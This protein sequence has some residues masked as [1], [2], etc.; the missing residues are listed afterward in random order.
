MYNVLIFD[1]YNVF[2]RVFWHN[3]STVKI[4]NKP[5][6]IDA[7]C[8]F[9]ELCNGYIEKFGMK[10]DCKIYWLFDNAKTSILKNR[11]LLDE[12]YKKNR[13][14][15]P[16]YFYDS[17]NLIELLLKFY[18]DDSFIFRK[19]SVEADDFVLPIIE[20]Y[21]KE[22]D[23]VLL[24]STDI[25]WCRALRDT[26]NNIKVHQYTRNNEILTCKT[27]EEKFGFKPSVKNVTFWKS[28][29][30]DD[31]DHI[32]ATL[33]NYPKE[34]FLDALSK[35]NH[36]DNFIQDALNGKLKYLDNAWIIRIKQ[37]E[38]RIRLNWNLISSAEISV[39]DLEQWKIECKYKP[40]K[41]LILYTTL[42]VLGRFD[43]RIKLDNKKDS[44][45]NMLN[46]ETL[47]R[48]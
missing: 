32:L 26:E 45:W 27:F 40:N 1:V 15:Q 3:D 46:G 12:N 28:I 42:N 2:H 25:D 24:F 47:D 20:S 13:R 10:K 39:T 36:V 6:A 8:K 17:L 34:Y 29:Y 11:K 48:A 43:N 44:I 18:R 9:F 22:N 37:L 31:S 19:M 38:Q 5:I 4:D 33:P 23:K 7:I 21:I 41:L 30:G 16:E 35:Y 14:E